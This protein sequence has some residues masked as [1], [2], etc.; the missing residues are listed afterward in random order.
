M[1]I[2]KTYQAIRYQFLD[3]NVMV[4]GKRTLIQFRGGTLRPKINGKYSTNDPA[5]I[6]A[7]DKRAGKSFRCIR[8]EG[9]PDVKKDEVKSKAPSA[10]KAQEGNKES[11]VTVDPSDQTETGKSL[12]EVI[13]VT[14][15]QEAREFLVSSVEGMSPGKLPNNQAIKNAA[16]KNGFSFPNLPQE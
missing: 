10:T 16:V 5:V 4:G 7:L 8:T 3:I 13:E 1:A 14:T 2:R 6:E 9:S 15:M 11:E 12:K